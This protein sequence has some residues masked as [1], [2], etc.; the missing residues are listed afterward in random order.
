[1]SPTGFTMSVHNAA[2]GLISIAAG[3]RGFTTSL[4][5][6]YDT[7]AMALFE[8]IGAVAAGQGPVIVACADEAS[9]QDL[10]PEP[11]RFALLAAAVLLAHPD[12]AGAQA[13]ATL[14]G[15]FAAGTTSATAAP[16]VLDDA[17]ARNPQAGLFDLVDAVLR[18]SFGTLR[19]D[20]G[21][22]AGW[23]VE[24]GPPPSQ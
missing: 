7:P 11:E 24:L 20:R 8:A 4:A 15:P 17:L 9:P 2:A 5:A 18:Q 14:S 23:L 21:Q 10:V 13:R 19:L 16:A 6:D 1:L 12:D 3:N 22:G